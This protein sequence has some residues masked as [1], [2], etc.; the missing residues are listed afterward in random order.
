M[1]RT[2]R[3][4]I[5]KGKYSNVL[6][7][8]LYRAITR[9]GNHPGISGQQ[10]QAAQTLAREGGWFWS[11]SGLVFWSGFSSESVD[12]ILP[13]AAAAASSLRVRYRI[14]VL[15]EPAAACAPAG[16]DCRSLS[17]C[18]RTVKYR[19]DY[20][21]RT[22][23]NRGVKAHL[24]VCHSPAARRERAKAVLKR[25]PEPIVDADIRSGTSTVTS[26]PLTDCPGHAEA[27][28]VW[29]ER[30]DERWNLRPAP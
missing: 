22:V 2:V 7:L 30:D 26:S 27:M 20:C 3:Y 25:P 9:L 23:P 11:G 17:Y 29:R 5:N 19:Y 14:L 4:C 28:Q 16:Q 21:T 8:V 13:S 12:P 24:P 6:V 18:T 15:V 10:Q 1:Y